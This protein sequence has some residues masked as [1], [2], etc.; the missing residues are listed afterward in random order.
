MKTCVSDSLYGENIFKYKYSQRVF[1]QTT[2][3]LSK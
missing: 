1:K 2:I 3:K